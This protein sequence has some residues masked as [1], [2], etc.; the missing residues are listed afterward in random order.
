MM[1]ILDEL[2]EY[3]TDCLNDK[4]PSCKKHK[5]ACQRFLSDVS[6][7]ILEDS[8]FYWS[9]EEAQKIVDWFAL[10]RHSKGEL[11]RQPI[12]LQPV[13]KFSICQLYGFRRKDNDRRRFTKYFKELAR[14]NAKSQELS[15]ILLYEISHGAVINGEIYET[16]CA[17]VKRD[18]SLIIVQEAWNMLQGSPL[19]SKFKKIGTTV[20]HR[21]TG[22]FIRALSKSDRQSGDGTN[23]A[24]LCLDEYHQHPTTEFYDLS[25]GSN[26][27]EPLLMII[28][29]A[30]EDLNSPCYQQE[31]SYCSN[32][33]NPDVDITN[34]EYL[35]D[36]HEADDTEDIGNIVEWQKANPIRMTYE[37]GIKQIQGAYKIA[38]EV[39][40]KMIGFMTKMLNIWVQYSDIGYMDM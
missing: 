20:I 10:L 13:Q 7:L 1:S 39:P 32:I 19:K 21:K 35:V 24:V 25:M 5:W 18:Q 17:G 29:T 37:N 4:I 23:P 12:V 34:D 27:K 2:I 22:S 40:E 30:G 14:K 6:N 38:N 8:D 9:E 36:I 11:S 33:L 26:S 31:Y 28:T 15:G 3:V 16:Y